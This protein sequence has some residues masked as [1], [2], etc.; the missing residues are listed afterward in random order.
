M[1][2]KLFCSL[3]IAL[4]ISGCGDDNTPSD[5][6]LKEQFSQQFHGLLTLDSIDVKETSVDGNKRTF[7][8]NGSLFST[9]D[10]YS[11]VASLPEYM[12]VEKTWDKDK[13][14]KFSATLNSVGSKDTGW[15]TRFSDLQMSIK[16]QGNPIRD[17]ATSDKYLVLGEASFDAKLNQ[18]KSEYADKKNKIEQ[19]TQDKQ[20]NEEALL[21]ISKEIGDYWGIDAEGNK[22]DKFTVYKNLKQEL[23]NYEKTDAPYYFEKKYN[24][25]VFDPAMEA[26]KQ[27][28]GK[29]SL[30]D[31]DD[32]RKE[33]R[34]AIAKHHEEYKAQSKIIK[35][36]IDEK[37]KSLDDG[38]QLLITKKR[39]IEKQQST[40]ANEINHLS[41]EYENWLNFEETI[42]QK[43]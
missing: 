19:L 4:L 16:P 39:S 1:K 14:I 29:Y 37:M 34:D 21:A 5:K 18:L 27:K 25:E 35:D 11:R 24:A 8:A 41:N 6:A 36:R 26:R 13:A 33:K 22:Q 15:S 10:L 9:N 12:V 42:K 38:L 17:L 7:A 28:L 23:L 3:L 31:F 43:K 30:S 32:I 2:G 40:L 20:K